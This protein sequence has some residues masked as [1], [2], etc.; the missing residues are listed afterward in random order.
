MCIRDRGYAEGQ[1]IVNPNAA[2]RLVS[3]LELTVSA[4]MN[5]VVMIEAGANQISNDIMFDAIM[6]RCV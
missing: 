4:S 1:L 5:K 2:Q 6:M 3:D